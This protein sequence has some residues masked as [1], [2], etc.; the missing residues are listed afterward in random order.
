MS[1]SALTLSRYPFRSVL[2]AT[3]FSADAEAAL[4]RALRLRLTPDAQVHVQ[5]VLEAPQVGP[6][7]LQEA[8]AELDQAIA[9]A[10]G[11]ATSPRA[12][13]ALGEGSPV[14][15][16]NLLA[17]LTEA[18][19][20]VV[21]RRGRSSADERLGATVRGLLTEVDRPVLIVSCRDGPVR[22]YERPLVAIDAQLVSANLL[23]LTS[24]VVRKDCPEVAVVHA[25]EA[26]FEG[27]RGLAGV[28]LNA[29]GERFQRQAQ[30]RLDEVMASLP[31]NQ[32]R[33]KPLVLHGDAAP[34]IAAEAAGRDADLVVLGTHQRTG[35]AR[36]FLGSVATDVLQAVRCDV[37]VL[38]TPAQERAFPSRPPH[39]GV[40]S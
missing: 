37:L 40:G 7:E 15:E 3:D 17:R 20:V 5:H 39:A 28:E 35:L 31:E 21:G 33:W 27:T 38:P 12:T 24:R 10:R 16:I 8:H 4:A 32:M 36:L 11:D 23:V 9:H 29:W 34:A 6:E 30:A 22:E 13:P 19:L 26:S 2:V 1:A 25:F 18:E 14:T